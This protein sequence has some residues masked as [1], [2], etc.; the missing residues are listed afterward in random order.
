MPIYQYK[1]QKCGNNFEVYQS[2]LSEFYLKLFKAKKEI[3]CPS[4]NAKDIVIAK[5]VELDEAIACGKTSG[6]FG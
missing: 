5:K 3:K 2:K 6:R 4:C 1:C